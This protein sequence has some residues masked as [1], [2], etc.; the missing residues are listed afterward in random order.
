VARSILCAYDDLLDGAAYTGA[1][2]SSKCFVLLGYDV[3]IDRTLK[4]WLLEI[5]HLPSL[6]PHSE[7]ANELKRRML[8]DLFAIVD[9]MAKRAAQHDALARAIW[10][11]RGFELQHQGGF[12][13]RHDVAACVRLDSELDVRGGF[14]LVFPTDEL[15]ASIVVPTSQRLPSEPLRKL[16]WWRRHQHQYQSQQ[17]PQPNV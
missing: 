8:A 15:V 13:S 5:N 17:Q 4:P 6:I 3:L 7:L 2:N 16:L 11:A 1:A 10:A 12:A 9:P 14:E